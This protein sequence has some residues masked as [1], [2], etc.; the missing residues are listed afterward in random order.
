MQGLNGLNGVAP[1]HTQT[2]LPAGAHASAAGAG[3]SLSPGERAELERL[4]A[5]ALGGAPR[6][7]APPA[8][9]GRYV[10]FEAE[11]DDDDEGGSDDYSD[12]EDEDDGDD[13]WPPAVPPQFTPAVV[14][15]K[16]RREGAA[17]STPHRRV[18]ALHDVRGRA[19]PPPAKSSAASS[20]SAPPSAPAAPPRKI[21]ETRRPVDHQDPRFDPY[22]GKT[23]RELN[24]IAVV[25]N[26]R[27][28]ARDNKE[29]LIRSLIAAGVRLG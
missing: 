18:T 5:S 2:H 17:T 14:G 3:S 10:E 4:R 16:R 13:G 26:V 23:M 11:E 7:R 15:G 28:R 9:R 21:G 8:K 29:D 19:L 24:G 6:H 22:Y 25:N 12:D 20:Y 27:V 1:A